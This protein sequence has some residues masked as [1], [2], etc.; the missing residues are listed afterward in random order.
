MRSW[1]EAGYAVEITADGSPTLRSLAGGEAMHHSGG[2]LAET[3]EIYGTAL[4]EVFQKI[5]E[6]AVH[7]L[8]LGLGYNELVTGALSVKFGKSYNLV[9]SESDVALSQ[10]FLAWLA[11]ELEVGTISETYEGICSRVAKALDVDCNQ[12]K[13]NLQGALAQGNWSLP[14]ALDPQHLPQGSFHCFLFDAFSSKTSPELWTQDFL[15]NYLQSLSQADALLATYAC[16]GNLKRSL[17]ATGFEL[18]LQEGFQGKKNS[19]L[20]RRGIFSAPLGPS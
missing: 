9:T 6:P 15:Q 4:A 8:G 19:T 18:V 20:G 1:Q 7:S 12:L 16:T 5:A 13:A 3:L 14:G 17:K 2:A 11:D 10:L